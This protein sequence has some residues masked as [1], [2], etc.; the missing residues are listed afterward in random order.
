[1]MTTV[2]GFFYAGLV[3]AKKAVNTF[4]MRFSSLGFVGIPW[5]LIGYSFAFGSTLM[6]FSLLHNIGLD[7][8]GTIPTLLFFAYQGTFAIITA[9]LISGSIVERMRFGPYIA[10]ITIWSLA[11]YAP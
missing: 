3:R 9:A 11:V 10:F 2:L 7:P 1:G 4:V 5:A 8:K 6:E